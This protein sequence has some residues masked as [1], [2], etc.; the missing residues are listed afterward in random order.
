MTCLTDRCKKHSNKSPVL[1]ILF[2]FASLT[3]QVDM[4]HPEGVIKMPA[5]PKVQKK[6]A[7]RHAKQAAKVF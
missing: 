3:V 4:D 7:G 6:P 1:V 5:P 2:A